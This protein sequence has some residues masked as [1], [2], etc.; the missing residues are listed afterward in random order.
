MI[1]LE[2]SANWLLFAVKA[3]LKTIMHCMLLNNELTQMAVVMEKTNDP[4]VN[5]E[6]PTTIS[7]NTSEGKE[8]SVH[9]DPIFAQKSFFREIGKE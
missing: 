9:T 8:I 4:T 2:N 1:T 3:L 6:N 5:V 7:K